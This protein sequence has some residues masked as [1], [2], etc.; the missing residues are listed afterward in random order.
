MNE[1]INRWM[2]GQQM[3]KSRIM[4]KSKCAWIKFQ[5]MDGRMDDG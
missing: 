5:W 2:D 4:D 3:N 1:W